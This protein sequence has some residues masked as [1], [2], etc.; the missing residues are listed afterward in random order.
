MIGPNG[1]GKSTLL[2]LIES[3]GE[4]NEGTLTVG[5]SVVTM[6]VDQDREGLSDDKLTVFQAI[7]DGADEIQLGSR[8]INSRAYCNLFNFNGNSQQKSVNLLSGGERNRLNLART[9]KK[10]GNLLMLDEPT[11]DLDVETLRVLEEAIVEFVGC[12]IVVSHDRSFL[13]RIATHILAFEDD[14]E[15]TVTWF[16]GNFS[17]YQENLIQRRGGVEPRRPKFRPIPTIA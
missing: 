15:G 5:D 6:Y 10:P 12:A 17:E 16:E 3:R 9:L 13:D 7:T 11:N 4:P 14:D 2:K 8:S 1:V